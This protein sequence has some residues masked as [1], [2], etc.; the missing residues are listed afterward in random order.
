VNY[1]KALGACALAA[2]G[3][4][5]L[6]GCGQS[7]EAGGATG[8]DGTA[9]TGS[10]RVDGSSTVLPISEALAEE[11]RNVERNVDVRVAASGTGGGFKKFAN[12]EIDITGASRAIEPSEVEAAKANGV[13]FVE[14]P[15]AFDG[16]TVVINQNNTFVDHLTVDE[17]RRIWEPNSTVKTWADVRQGWPSQPIKLYGAG[18]DSGTF[19]YF[20]KAI[21]GKEKSS[22]TDYQASEN[23]NVLVQ[24]VVGDENS[25]GYFGYAYFEENRTRLKA[26]PI[27]HEGR[28]VSP[29]QETIADGTYQPLSRPLF[30]YINRKS[31]EENTGVQA[32]VRYVLGEGRELLDEVGYV[33]LPE[34]AYTLSLDRVQNRIP[35]TVFHGAEVGV[36]LEDLL[37]RGSNH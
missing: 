3:S 35:G 9:A 14:I 13:E 24:G 11:F 36:R 32:F 6:V 18:T 8:T 1:K 29:S 33:R 37:R 23:D 15:V 19:D 12:G 34:E 17:L 27:M 21:V 22:R 5:G 20:T 25:L 26:V 10:V 31:L 7:N 4:L 2:I 30:Y 28:A 16:I